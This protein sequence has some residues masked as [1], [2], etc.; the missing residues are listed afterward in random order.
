VCIYKNKNKILFLILLAITLFPSLWTNAQEYRFASLNAQNGLPSLNIFQTFQ[1]SNG[2]IWI[3]TDAGVSRY[4][5]KSFEHYKFSPG[6]SRHISHNVITNMVEDSEGNIWLASEHGLNKI[7]PDGTVIIYLQDPKNLNSLH[8]DWT[9]SLYTNEQDELWIGTGSGLN[10]YDKLKDNFQ[11]VP[12]VE[13]GKTHLVT[14]YAIVEDK[15]GRIFTITSYGLALLNRSKMVLEKVVAGNIKHTELLGKVTNTGVVDSQGI[16]WM[17]SETDGL[18][19]YN[20]KTQEVK[21]FRHE[22]DNIN[23]I[24]DNSI[25]ALSENAKGELWIGHSYKGISILN[26]QTDKIQHIQHQDFVP[27]SLPSNVIS[28]ILSDKSGMV[29]IS[30]DNGVATYN[31]YSSASYIYRKKPNNK[32]LSD[33]LINHIVVDKNV[34]WLATGQGINSLTLDTNEINHVELDK[35]T[36]YQFSNDSIWNISRINNEKLW[37]ISDQGLSLFNHKE[38]KLTHFDNSEGNKYSFPSNSFYTLTKD[39]GKGVWITGYI[40]VGLLWF[41][42]ENGVKKQFLNVEGNKYFDDGNFSYQ[43]VIDDNGYMWMGT[44]DGVFKVDLETGV[45]TQYNL[46][47]DGANVRVTGVIRLAAGDI[48]AITQGGGLVRISFSG[49]NNRTVNIKTMTQKG[50]LQNDQL[51]SLVAQGED[52]LWFTSSN[53]LYMYHIPTEEVIHYKSLLLDKN[54]NFIEAAIAIVDNT[55]LLGTNNGLIRVEIDQLTQNKFNSPVQ[56]TEVVYSNKSTMAISDEMFV[57]TLQLD[58]E[59]ANIQI[60]FASLDYTAPENNHYRYQLKGFD[61]AWVYSGNTNFVHYTN[62]DPGTYQF[63]VEGTNSDGVWSSHQSSLKFE[64]KMPIWYYLLI[65]L[66]AITLA[67]SIRYITF[68]KQKHI[69]LHKRANY[70]A[71]TGLAN[72]YFLNQ[73]LEKLVSDKNNHF[74]IAFLDIDHFKEIN[75]TLGHDA[76][77]QLIIQIGKRLQSCLRDHDLL[78]RLGGDEFAIIIKT[79]PNDNGLTQ[80]VERMHKRVSALYHIDGEKVKSSVSI[81]VAKFPCDGNDSKT[82]LKNADFAMYAA[83]SAGRNHVN[84]YN[85]AISKSILEKYTIRNAL[86]NA[87]NNQEF[88]L[89]YQPKCD[90]KSGKIIGF[91]GLIRWDRPNYGVIPPDKFIPEAEISGAIIDIGRWVLREACTQIS[92]WHH[93]ELLVDNVSVNISAMQLLEPDFCQTLQV[94][95]L[96]TGA[97]PSKLEL[98]ITETVLIENV[99]KVQHVLNE[100]ISLDVSIALDDFGTGYS[101]LSYLTQFPINTLKIDRSFI[102]ALETEESSKAILKNIFSLAKDLNMAVV[103]EGVE[104]QEHLDILRSYQC[105]YVQGYFYSPA[106]PSEEAT[107]MLLL[108]Q[109]DMSSDV[110]N[111]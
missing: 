41:D 45:S 42:Q 72:R 26:P 92:Q 57:E 48:W 101:S 67:V 32:G 55:L 64:V 85:A 50:E 93:K 90:G 23:S 107:Q 31:P 53:E 84:Y 87:L 11:F 61:N 43:T 62:L 82:L 56:I 65:M 111:F 94:I 99:E 103:A 102:W 63:V 14:V 2:F 105:Q 74:A 37:F 109:S 110:A 70:D 78:S 27:S 83:K 86:E 106:A 13:N 60:Y 44:T 38:N 25:Y 54:F 91:E 12:Y 39:N 75:D 76:G 4:D 47:I 22:P 17:G 81:G 108:Q 1:Q 59:N 7:L 80:I 95:L 104:T 8:S 77:D 96:E 40:D 49:P 66:S 46:G 100:I 52:R 15:H 5:G 19:S 51:K 69:E 24:S 29:W 16:L 21:N 89:Y 28:H 79:S 3:A 9:V 73:K 58:R 33:N 88:E 10:L 97:L 34:V 36:Q 68:R 35:L 18:V 71:L 98:E 6:S 20:P 30:T